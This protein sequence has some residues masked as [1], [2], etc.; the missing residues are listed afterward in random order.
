MAAP[1]LR[2]ESQAMWLPSYVALAPD[3]SSDIRSS[4][5]TKE[6]KTLE[7]QRKR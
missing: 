5:V 4:A 7:R 6:L 2:S 3:A 1:P